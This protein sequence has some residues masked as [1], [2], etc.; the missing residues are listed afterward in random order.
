MRPHLFLSISSHGF[1]HLIQGLSVIH[2]LKQRIPFQLTIECRYEKS[3]LDKH[4]KD[5]EFQHIRRSMDIGLIQP[6]P[7]EVDTKATYKAYQ[8]F[9]MNYQANKKY[10]IKEL[11]RLKV[12]MLIADVPYLPL[13]A[14][15]ELS[16]PAIAIASLSWDEIIRAYFPLKDEP[17]EWYRTALNA[18]QQTSLAIMPEPCMPGNAFSNKLVVPPILQPG[19]RQDMIRQQLSLQ[20]CDDR[21]LVLCSMGGIK[22]ATYPVEFLHEFTEVHWLLDTAVHYNAEHI[23]SLHSPLLSSKA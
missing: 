3:L 22:G 11:H 7:M 13:E 9:H 19:G 5:I 21:P 4:L 15:A 1:G 16:I 14:A 17:L 6:N 10:Y 2:A 18:Y 8:N 20:N 23:H 12:D